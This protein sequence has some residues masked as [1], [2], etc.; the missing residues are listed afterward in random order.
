MAKYNPREAELGDRIQ[1]TKGSPKKEG[2]IRMAD[3][4]QVFVVFDD[5]TM[6]WVSYGGFYIT[7]KGAEITFLDGQTWYDFSMN[8]GKI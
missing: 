1:T 2:T 7:R 3:E 5:L 4:E 8:G 6:D